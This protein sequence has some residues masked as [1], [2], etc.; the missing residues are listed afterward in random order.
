M[1]ISPLV[2]PPSKKAEL[3]NALLALLARAAGKLTWLTVDAPTVS[4]M[5]KFES[6]KHVVID[7]HYL[8]DSIMLSKA[9]L[10]CLETL[11]LSWSSMSDPDFSRLDTLQSL[12][13]SVQIE[14]A[15]RLRLPSGCELHLCLYDGTNDAYE[16]KHFWYEDHLDK[17][18][19]ALDTHPAALRS[20]SLTCIFWHRDC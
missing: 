18:V 14:F 3:Y 15:D 17:V 19:K 13:V 10:P 6:L 8:E 9:Q 12:C 5:P 1:C 20:L 2:F 4:C 16:D 7:L 11:S